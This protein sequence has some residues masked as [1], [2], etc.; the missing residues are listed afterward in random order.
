MR[1]LIVVVITPESLAEL[2]S[3]EIFGY[4][5]VGVVLVLHGAVCLETGDY[6]TIGGELDRCVRV[7]LIVE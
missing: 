3:A 2:A 5:S 6:S 1:Y 4:Y 7:L